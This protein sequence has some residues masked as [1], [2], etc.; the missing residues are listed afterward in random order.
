VYK[1]TRDL[2]VVQALLGHSNLAQTAWY[3]Q[4]EL[5]EVSVDVLELAKLNP[6][7]ETIQ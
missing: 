2:R 6:T 4:D 3:L 7:T 1:A 5:T